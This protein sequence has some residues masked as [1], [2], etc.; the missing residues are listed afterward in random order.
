M[1]SGHIYS[2]SPKS[3]EPEDTLRF[4]EQRGRKLTQPQSERIGTEFGADRNGRYLWAVNI[5]MHFFTLF[6]FFLKEG[7]LFIG[8][9]ADAEAVLKDSPVGT[10]LFRVPFD[11]TD[12]EYLKVSI[13]RNRGF[14]H[15]LVDIPRKEFPGVICQQVCDFEYYSRLLECCEREGCTHVYNETLGKCFSF[16]EVLELYGSK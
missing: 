2:G 1:A 4:F 13:K 9:G 14:S 10:V 6:S 15:L 8:S 5:A 12:D 3:L 16:S 7:F 11:M